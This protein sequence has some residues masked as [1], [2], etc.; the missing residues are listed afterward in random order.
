MIH[1]YVF[2]SKSG[3]KTVFA[4]C[5]ANAVKR[6]KK[7]HPGEISLSAT[8]ESAAWTIFCPGETWTLNVPASQRG[9]NRA[10]RKAERRLKKAKEEAARNGWRENCN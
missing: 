7:S 4:V 5:D 1:K 10:I 8:K 3:C 9:T 6:F 2:L